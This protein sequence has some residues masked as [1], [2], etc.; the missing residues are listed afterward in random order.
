MA[1][2]DE[3]MELLPPPTKPLRATD[4]RNLEQLNRTI[5]F[6]FPTDFIAFGKRYGTGEIEVGGYGL[7]IGNP[8]DASYRKWVER[9]CGIVRT[10]GDPEPLRPTRFY[11]ESNGLIPFAEDLSG[12]LLFFAPAG[13]QSFV[14]SVNLGDT[15]FAVEYKR[16]FV[17]FL[18]DLLRGR[19]KPEYFPN[20]DI[21]A[22][23]ATFVKRAWMR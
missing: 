7:L 13:A 23:K 20:V 18:I 2:L 17:D 6:N 1:S 12:D 10:I 19:L 9:T 15:S 22:G 11:P 14:C 8:F 16:S 21:R 5:H 3:L 4:E